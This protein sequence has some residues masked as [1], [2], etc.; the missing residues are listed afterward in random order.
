MNKLIF[1][2]DK[3]MLNEVQKKYG[4]SLI[5]VSY[6]YINGFMLKKGKNYKPYKKD[7]LPRVNN[8]DRIY[9]VLAI[10]ERAEVFIRILDGIMGC[11]K[12][13][14]GENHVMDLNHRFKVRATP[15]SFESIDDFLKMKYKSK[16]EIICD[17]YYCNPK[18]KSNKIP[19][20]NKVRYDFDVDSLIDKIL[21]EE[22][23]NV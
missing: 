18:N 12:S 7:V 10:L 15:I 3:L 9:V 21:L 8:N 23:E 19:K 11:S 4:I 20:K 1:I 2:S 13:S 17:A 22:M 6:G 5:F 16:E 14:L